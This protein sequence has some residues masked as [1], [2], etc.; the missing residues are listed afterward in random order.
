MILFYEILIMMY[1][2]QDVSA[3]VAHLVPVTRCYEA[4]V[5]SNL[6]YTEQLINPT[7]ITKLEQK[8]Q[9][10]GPASVPKNKKF[11]VIFKCIPNL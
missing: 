3:V 6:S 5:S 8:T 9:I 7:K 2:Q 1:E 10:N 4:Y 11:I